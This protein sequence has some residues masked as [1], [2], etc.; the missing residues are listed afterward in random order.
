MTLQSP[1]ANFNCLDISPLKFNAAKFFLFSI[2]L[3][4]IIPLTPS[5]PLSQKPIR[6]SASWAID[7]EPIRARGII[8]NYTGNPHKVTLFAIFKPK[9]AFASILFQNNSPVFL[10]KSI[11]RH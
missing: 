10:F 2:F 3:T 6:P 4:T 9:R 8:V 11:F 5:W 1:F 7:S